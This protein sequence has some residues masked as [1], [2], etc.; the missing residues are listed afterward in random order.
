[1]SENLRHDWECYEWKQDRLYKLRR[2]DREDV[3]GWTSESEKRSVK[4]TGGWD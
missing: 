2:D 1:M 4:E 3:Y